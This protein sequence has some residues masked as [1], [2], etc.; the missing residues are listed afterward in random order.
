MGNT[1]MNELMSQL[2]ITLVEGQVYLLRSDL[3]STPELLPQLDQEFIQVMDTSHVSLVH[4]ISFITADN[5]V[6]LREARK[7]KYSSHPRM[8]YNVSIGAF[9]NPALRFIIA[10]SISLTRARYKDVN[11]LAEACAFLAQKDHFLPPLH[12]WNL[13]SHVDASAS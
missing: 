3:P 11:T 5:T 12:T 2:L 13:P 10:V 1:S 8:G 4:L 6:S 9:H 7:A